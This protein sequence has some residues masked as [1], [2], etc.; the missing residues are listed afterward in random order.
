MKSTQRF[1]GCVCERERDRQKECSEIIVLL[2]VVQE[3][4][5]KG[6][7]HPLLVQYPQY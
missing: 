7:M 2:P 4:W 3:S 6:K 1:M 5:L